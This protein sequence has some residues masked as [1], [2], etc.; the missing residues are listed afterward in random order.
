[1][2]RKSGAIHPCGA[3]AHHDADDGSNN[4]PQIEFDAGWGSALGD[5]NH[6]EL[7]IRHACLMEALG[8]WLR[9]SL[10]AWAAAVQISASKDFMAGVEKL[11]VQERD[12]LE[13]REK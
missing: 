6:V 9:L 4:F 3:E 1:V 5:G 11:P 7:D 12:D 2:S 8:A 10:A 13:P